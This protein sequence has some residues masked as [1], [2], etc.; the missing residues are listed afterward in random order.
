MQRAVD[1]HHLV[2]EH[3]DV[4]GPRL[5]HAVVARPGAVVLMPLPDVAF[6]GRLGIELELM[7][8]NILAEILPQRFDQPRM[9]AEQTKHF[10]ERVSGECRAR[11]A[12]LLAPDLLAVEFQD[13]FGVVAQQRDLILGKAVREEQIALLVELFLLA[14]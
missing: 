6:E 4:H 5:R 11:R 13:R 1:R 3:G 8:V 7:D 14:G 10:V 2:E 12:G 9:A